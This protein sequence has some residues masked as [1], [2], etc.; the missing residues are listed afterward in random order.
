MNR[1]AASD[2]TRE[3][4]RGPDLS[5]G[6]SI[7]SEI[8]TDDTSALSNPPNYIMAQDEAQN[9]VGPRPFDRDWE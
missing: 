4:A 2:A 3:L 7:T 5:V 1:K 8:K 9:K 6:I